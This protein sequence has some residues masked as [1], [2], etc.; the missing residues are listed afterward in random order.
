MDKVQLMNALRAFTIETTKDLM[1]P[2]RMQKISEEQSARA[3]AVYTQ[4][5]PDEQNAAK[6]APYILHQLITGKDLQTPGHNV[7][8]SASVRTIICV[9][10]EDEQDGGMMLLEVAERLR[11]Q[12][13]KQVIVQPFVLDLESGLEFMAYPDDTAPYFVGEMISTWQLPPIKREVK[14]VWGET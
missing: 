1:L 7:E 12:L 5:L 11:I 10:N 6:K 13:L 3:P 9:Y 8:C 2:T 4:R 14:Q